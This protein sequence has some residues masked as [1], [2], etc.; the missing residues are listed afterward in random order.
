LSKTNPKPTTDP[1]PPVTSWGR[2]ARHASAQTV[3]RLVPVAR[4]HR[5]GADHLKLDVGNRPRRHQPGRAW[6]DRDHCE[7]RHRRHAGSCHQRRRRVRL[8][9]S[10]TGA[11]HHQGH[12]ERLQAA[13]GQGTRR[14]R[15]QPPRRRR[16]ALVG[17]QR[18]RVGERER[19]RRDRRHDHDVASGRARSQAGDESLDSRPRPGLAAQD[20]AWRAAPRQRP[21]NLRRQLRDARAR[22]PGRT[23]PDRLR[24]RHQRRRRRRRRQLQRRHQP[25]RDRRS[26]RADELVHRGVRAERRRAGELH[27]QARRPAVPRHGVYLPALH[28]SERDELLQQP[29]QHP[30]AGLP[31]FDHRRQPRRSGA[32]DQEP[33]L[34]LFGRRHAVEGRQHP[35]PLYDADRARA[36]RRL[37][38]DA[39][40]VRRVD[41]R[42]RSGDERAVPRQQDPREPRQRG[43][44]RTPQPAA[45][46]ECVRIGLQ[47]SDAGAEHPPSAPPASRPRRLAVQ[48][49]GQPR[50]QVSDLVHEERRLGSRRPIVAVGP[51]P[52]A[53]RLHRRSGEVRLHAHHQSQHRPR[54]WG[55]HVLQHRGRTA[56]GQHGAGRH[57][58]LE[59]S[60]ARQPP[61]V[62]AGAQSA[63]PDPTRPVRWAPEQQQRSA[64]PDLRRP[65]ADLRRR[66]GRGGRDQPDAHAR[67]A[68]VQGRRDAR[69]RTFRRIR[70]TPASATPTPSSA[71]SA[72]TPRTSAASATTAGRIPGPGSSRTRGRRRAS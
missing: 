55:R 24:R 12:D 59:L 35:P 69:V 49:E 63:R 65:L 32:E 30:E 47:L 57:S 20:P 23:R 51:R 41:R 5:R 34:L 66:H 37:L 18:G 25:R 50:D 9:G 44:P 6:R 8:R 61:A 39:H 16:P 68:H 29:G 72:A 21:G 43:E 38:A 27:H 42:S 33:V 62:C 45:A 17:R 31:L 36:R 40:D 2:K 3:R 71:S 15:Q 28:R 13:R 56:R 4:G 19:A 70:T 53:L 1:A 11:L 67:L 60:G 10:D 46:A 26:Q 22:H 14:A 54:G 7:R 58:A 48:R 52:P 64:E